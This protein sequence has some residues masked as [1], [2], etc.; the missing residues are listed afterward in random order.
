MIQLSSVVRCQSVKFGFRQNC[1]FKGSIPNKCWFNSSVRIF[2]L[3]KIFQKSFNVGKCITSDFHLLFS[4]SE[5]KLQSGLFGEF[6][7][8]CFQDLYR[9]NVFQKLFCF[10]SEESERSTLNYSLFE[11]VWFLLNNSIMYFILY[12]CT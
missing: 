8:Q 12:I 9:C 4:R 5:N 2:L 10:T 11:K 1:D 3:D 7:C 6:Y